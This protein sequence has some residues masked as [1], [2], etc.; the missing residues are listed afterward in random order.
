MGHRHRY[1]DEFRISG[2]AVGDDFHMPA[3]EPSSTRKVLVPVPGTLPPTI[4][5]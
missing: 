2:W 5:V 1:L 4:V 3:C